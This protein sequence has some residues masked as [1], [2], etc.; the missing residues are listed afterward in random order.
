MTL[1]EP[2]GSAAVPPAPSPVSM[3]W[4]TLP[5]S[6]RR[7]LWASE[8]A[9]S[10][11][12]CTARGSSF[13][14]SA[15]CRFILLPPPPKRLVWRAQVTAGAFQ[16]FHSKHPRLGVSP[17]CLAGPWAFPG[18]TC[19]FSQVH[20]SFPSRPPLWPRCHFKVCRFVP[21]CEDS[22]VLFYCGQRA[23]CRILVL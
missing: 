5:A 15:C 16:L 21:K 10:A 9:V 23:H 4:V 1:V 14:P 2:A 12:H 20:T 11:F 3:T 7:G 22:S 6:P 13:F 17:H 8:L 19:I 18:C